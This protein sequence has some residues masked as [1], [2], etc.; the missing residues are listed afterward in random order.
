MGKNGVEFLRYFLKH[1]RS[2]SEETICTTEGKRALGTGEEEYYRW[3]T[4]VDIFHIRKKDECA[5]Q[6]R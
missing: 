4:A 6:E 5:G 2:V 3:V 1:V